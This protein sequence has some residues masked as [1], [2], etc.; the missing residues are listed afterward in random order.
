M[1][2]GV[3]CLW[4]L[5]SVFFCPVVGYDWPPNPGPQLCFSKQ[6]SNKNH[7]THINMQIT[8]QT[9]HYHGHS[10]ILVWLNNNSLQHRKKYCSCRSNKTRKTSTF[11]Y[12]SFFLFLLFWNVIDQVFTYKKQR[13]KL[14][15][16]MT[17][18]FL[19]D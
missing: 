9:I 14:C 18:L 15:V 7:I 16:C 12:L 10:C 8:H 17:F 4:L 19:L 11:L 1:T 3:T 5:W 13:I 2:V 6:E